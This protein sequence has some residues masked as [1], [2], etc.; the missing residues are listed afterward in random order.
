MIYR[1]DSFPI[2]CLILQAQSFFKGHFR[3]LI[4]KEIFLRIKVFNDDTSTLDI[5][6]RGLM[7]YDTR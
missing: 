1:I 4:Q 3:G 2:S 7:A 6:R 5:L